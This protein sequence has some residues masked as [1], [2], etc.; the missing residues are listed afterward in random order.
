VKNEH[1]AFFP[2]NLPKPHQKWRSLHRLNI[3][4]TSWLT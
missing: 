3:L 4:I 1:I 2:E